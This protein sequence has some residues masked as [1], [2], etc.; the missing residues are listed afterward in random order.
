MSNNVFLSSGGDENLIDGSVNFNG[1]SLTAQNLI[2]NTSLRVGNNKTIVSSKLL[3]SDTTGLQEVL[4]ST[5]QN[6]LG[7][8]IDANGY[9]IINLA[10]PSQSGDGVNYSTLVDES[11]TLDTKIDTKLSLDGTTPMTG[12]LIWVLTKSQ[13]L[14]TRLYRV[15]ML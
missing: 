15:L 5:I 9:K 10:N 12:D 8:D 7:N 13:M 2:P 14:I 11:K 1:A 3:I 6:P 4:D